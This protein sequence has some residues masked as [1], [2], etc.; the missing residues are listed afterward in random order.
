MKKGKLFFVD[1]ILFY[2]PATLTTVF[3]AAGDRSV[4]Y[5]AGASGAYGRAG[6]TGTYGAAGVAGAT[7]TYAAAEA[8]ATMS[9]TST[10]HKKVCNYCILF[11]LLSCNKY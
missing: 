4:Y 8:T 5:T 7:G 11:I 3:G 9:P 6:P 2:W 10:A 1:T